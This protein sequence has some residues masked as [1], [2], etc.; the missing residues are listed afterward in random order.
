MKYVIIL[1]ILLWSLSAFSQSS[2]EGKWNTTMDNT[3]IEIYKNSGKWE[4]K[5]V[6]SDNSKA[7]PGKVVMRN[8]IQVD[9]HWEGE[10][11]IPMLRSW[12]NAKLVPGDEEMSVTAYSWLISRTKV[13]KKLN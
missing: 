1:I 13:W 5:V 3:I 6:S 12:L 4:G 9:T 8:L 10:F 7:E 11:Y 2:I